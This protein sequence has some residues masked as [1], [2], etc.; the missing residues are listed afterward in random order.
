MFFILYSF[1]FYILIFKEKLLKYYET[2][3][4]FPKKEIIVDVS[5]NDNS[6]LDNENEN[7]TNVYEDDSKSKFLFQLDNSKI[8]KKK[9]DQ[10]SKKKKQNIEFFINTIKEKNAEIT[11]SYFIGRKN[12]E[13]E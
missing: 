7:N 6:N 3:K 10:E 5:E 8:L 4:N 2:N 12:E 1:I 11:V 9:N 13:K